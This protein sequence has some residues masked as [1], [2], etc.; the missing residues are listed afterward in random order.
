MIN[1]KLLF[2]ITILSN[3]TLTNNEKHRVMIR[4]QVD[5]FAITRKKI[6]HKNYRQNLLFMNCVQIT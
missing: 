3:F 5:G 4:R 2:S 1:V 6:K